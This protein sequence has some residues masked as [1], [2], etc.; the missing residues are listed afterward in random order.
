MM[1]LTRCMPLFGR[2][3]GLRKVHT[4][5][6]R[7]EPPDDAPFLSRLTR[8]SPTTTCGIILSSPRR[9]TAKHLNRSTSCWHR[10]QLKLNNLKWWM[11][12]IFTL[13]YNWQL[14]KRYSRFCQLISEMEGELCRPEAEGCAADW[15]NVK[16][17]Q[18]LVIPKSWQQGPVPCNLSGYRENKL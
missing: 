13:N 16:N 9:V 8:A 14:F 15:E 11:K 2:A 10:C 3:S 6:W 1:H 5:L 17:L 18:L 7:I 12:E 4:L